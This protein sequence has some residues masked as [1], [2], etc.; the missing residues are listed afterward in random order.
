MKYK[1]KC[2]KEINNFIKVLNDEK[3]EVISTDLT[4]VEVLLKDEKEF[5]LFIKILSFFIVYISYIDL[6]KENFTKIGV[7]KKEM[8]QILKE[9]LINLEDSEYFPVLTEILVKD[10]F[11]N[12]NTLNVDS[13]R[14]FNMKGFKE[15]IQLI[16]KD[17]IDFRE[18][19]KSEVGEGNF[20][21]E[22]ISKSEEIIN[23]D[24][25]V[26]TVI[27][28]NAEKNGIDLKEFEEINV[29]GNEDKLFFKNKSKKNVDEEFFATKLGSSLT[30]KS[31]N[32]ESVNDVNTLRDILLCL[33]IL[34]VFP[35]NKII[36]HKSVSDKAKDLF[37]YNL[38]VFKKE[39]EKTFNIVI[40]NGC[41]SCD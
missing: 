38:E 3:I 15:E 10:Y 4:T 40:C 33:C 36:I 17:I 39:N 5:D 27:R 35:V 11:R 24:S 22:I 25:E 12:M 29:F 28:E 19:E 20:L 13:F 2:N 9:E 8:N 16:A 30:Y 6:M 18:F 14:L 26:F 34:N 41:E 31:E 1:V 7:A 21:D 32:V 37:L 23:Q